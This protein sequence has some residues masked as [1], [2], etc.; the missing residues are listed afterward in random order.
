MRKPV[1]F[2]LVLLSAAAPAQAQSSI[3]IDVDNP[4][5]APGEST[6]VTLA[7]L[8]HDGFAMAGVDTDLLVSTGSEGWSD[9]RL[10]APMNG[11]GTSAGSLT[12]LGVE[13]ILAGKLN[14]PATGIPPDPNPILFWQGV[15]TAPTDVATPFDV[16][17]STSTSRFDVYIERPSSTTRSLL[18]GFTEGNATIRVI[19]APASALVLAGLALTT[20]RRR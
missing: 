7:A 19:P 11:P 5:L 4:T 3:V 6:G 9:L 17:L 8:W 10:I 2:C 18:P 13:G 12:P 20:R 15:Y 1:S 14:F 16:D